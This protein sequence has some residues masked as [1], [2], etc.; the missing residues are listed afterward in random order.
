MSKIK[1]IRQIYAVK[2]SKSLWLNTRLIIFGK[3]SINQE[4]ISLCS[5]GYKRIPNEKKKKILSSGYVS[6]ILAIC[7]KG[8]WFLLNQTVDSD[9]FVLFIRIKQDW[10]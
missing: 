9:K 3:L 5:W 1:A 4:L 8:L 6:L 2:I 10:L 7:W